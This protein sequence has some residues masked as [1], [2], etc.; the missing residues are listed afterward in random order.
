MSI[1]QLQLDTL[2]AN[3]LFNKVCTVRVDIWSN[4]QDREPELLDWSALGHIDTVYAYTK[5]WVRTHRYHSYIYELIVLPKMLPIPYTS[6]LYLRQ[7]AFILNIFF[8]QG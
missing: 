5:E 3:G 2:A 6:T 1:T 4:R 8:I 7:Q